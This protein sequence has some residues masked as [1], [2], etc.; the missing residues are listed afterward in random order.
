MVYVHFKNGNHRWSKIQGTY[1]EHKS[2]ITQDYICLDCGIKARRTDNLSSILLLGEY[3]DRQTIHCNRLI[4]TKFKTMKLLFGTPH[5]FEKQNKDP[6]E[7]KNG[8]KYD[9]YKCIKC[10]IRGKH[11]EHDTFLTLTEK[12]SADIYRVENCLG[13]GVPL[14]P[15]VIEITQIQRREKDRREYF[16]FK[17]GSRH[18]TVNPHR[19]HT[20]EMDGVWVMGRKKPVKLYPGEFKPAKRIR[21]KFNSK[22]L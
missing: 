7:N 17:P 6:L 22:N 12:M 8:E 1:K 5:T 11:F 20:N 2:Y 9:I 19:H 4:R 16:K 21:T 15:A 10:N 3:S 14:V 18:N 13:V